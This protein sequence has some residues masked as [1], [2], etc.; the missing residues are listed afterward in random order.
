[1][2]EMKLNTPL[3]EATVRDL[4][5]GDVVYLDGEILTARDEQLWLGVSLETV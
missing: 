2:K 4:R 1:M 5:I 3:S